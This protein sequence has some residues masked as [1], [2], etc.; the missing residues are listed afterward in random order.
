MASKLNEWCT[1]CAVLA[2]VVI[3]G[4]SLYEVISTDRALGPRS[5]YSI[6]A[7]HDV[8]WFA[9]EKHVSPGMRKSNSER[10]GV[11]FKL[12]DLASNSTILLC[13]STGL[14]DRYLFGLSRVKAVSRSEWSN[15]PSDITRIDRSDYQISWVGPY[16]IFTDVSSSEN[17][18]HLSVKRIDEFQLFVESTD[19]CTTG[20]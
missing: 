1:P 13:G 15:D 2:T 18:D 6:S 7:D 19:S 17:R 5:P 11:Y 14:F 8:R 9:P 10:F 16:E 4:C 20:L 12:S 3:V